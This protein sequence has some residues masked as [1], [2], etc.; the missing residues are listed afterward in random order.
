MIFNK[1]KN[2]FCYKFWLFDFKF[3]KRSPLRRLFQKIKKELEFI[4]EFLHFVLLEEGRSFF[5]FFYYVL[6]FIYRFFF[7]VLLKICKK[8]DFLFCLI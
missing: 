6:D 5:S 3:R 7:Y 4:E 2:V 8:V 1:K